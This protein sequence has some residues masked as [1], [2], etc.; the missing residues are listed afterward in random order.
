[1]T[2]R[3]RRQAAAPPA[4]IPPQNRDAE[5][6]VLGGAFCDPESL[7]AVRRPRPEDF[8]TEAHRTIFAHMLRVADAGQP[9]DLLTVQQSLTDA[10]ELAVIHG[11][12]ALALVAEAGALVIPAHMPPTPTWC[13]R[14]R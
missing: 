6:A 13:G 12:A 8:Y 1:M 14:S 2:T 7:T 5:R 11:P 3:P 4:E 9:V 10:E